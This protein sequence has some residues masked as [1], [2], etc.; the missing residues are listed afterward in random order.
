MKQF[1]F[2]ITM[3]C[4]VFTHVVLANN[5]DD[6]YDEAWADFPGAEDITGV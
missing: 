4:R 5:S 3:G 2:R 6:A 1:T